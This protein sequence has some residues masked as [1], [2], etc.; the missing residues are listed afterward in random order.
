MDDVI[1]NTYRALRY[2]GTS[3]S[4]SNNTLYAEFTDKEDW[5]FTSPIAG[6][7]FI[8]MYELD[9]DPVELDNLASKA[10]APDRLRTEVNESRA[11]A[12]GERPGL[13]RFGGAFFP[14]FLHGAA[15]Q[16]AAAPD[17]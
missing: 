16:G 15:A 11:D 17:K 6:S 7:L 14:L 4:G 5:N 12:R 2:V 8:E 1:S 3:G 10:S 13:T 9:S